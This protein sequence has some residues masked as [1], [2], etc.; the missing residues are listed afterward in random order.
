LVL[1]GGFASILQALINQDP[2]LLDASLFQL[3]LIAFPV[4][5]VSICVMILAVLD[6]A[7]KQIRSLEDW[8]FYNHLEGI[9]STREFKDFSTHSEPPINGIYDIRVYHFL[10][11][12]WLPILLI[13]A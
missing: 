10:G 6:A 4:V 13:I 3:L 2:K 7:K 11:S 1:S 5:G 12:K 8:W 9:T